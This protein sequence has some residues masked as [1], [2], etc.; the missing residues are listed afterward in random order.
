[1]DKNTTERKVKLLQEL[2][3]ID[4]QNQMPD[5]MTINLRF[6]YLK[7]DL[8]QLCEN[9]LKGKCWAHPNG[10]PNQNPK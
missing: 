4:G 7:Q 5:A 2:M 1:M 6:Q 8:V 3:T 10:L 9:C